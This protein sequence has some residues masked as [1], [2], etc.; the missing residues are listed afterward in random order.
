MV[1]EAKRKN[2]TYRPHALESLAQFTKLH[3]VDIFSEV[4]EITLDVFDSSSEDDE[5]MDVDSK[6]PGAASS[7]SR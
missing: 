2:A 5:S 1:R 3:K 6:T 4:L 7:K